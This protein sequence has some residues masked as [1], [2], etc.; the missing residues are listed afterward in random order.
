MSRSTVKNALTKTYCIT[1]PLQLSPCINTAKAEKRNTIIFQVGTYFVIGGA[2]VIGVETDGAI[3]RVVIG[4]DIDKE[5]DIAV[6]MGVIADGAK[7]VGASIGGSAIDDVSDSVGAGSI[8][9]V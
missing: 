7:E 6:D 4:G 3:D 8:F 1:L 9:G 5:F 2:V